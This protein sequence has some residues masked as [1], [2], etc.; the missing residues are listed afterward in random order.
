MEC[1]F[2]N[3]HSTQKWRKRRGWNETDDIV[4]FIMPSFDLMFT[5][6]YEDE[7][8][9][10]YNVT[11]SSLR[12]SLRVPSIL[13]VCIQ[14]LYSTKYSLIHN[15]WNDFHCWLGFW[16]GFFVH[17]LVL[18]GAYRKPYFVDIKLRLWIFQRKTQIT[19]FLTT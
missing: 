5:I 7:V 6:R 16:I 11:H 3:V 10:D 9:N 14:N 8:C 12:T 13:S 17:L 18:I 19:I 2:Q 15:F 1:H 4:P